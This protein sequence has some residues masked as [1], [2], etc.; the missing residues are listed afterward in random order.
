MDMDLD[1]NYIFISHPD[2]YGTNE[3]IHHMCC[4]RHFFL[5][6]AFL[7]IILHQTT[8]YKK[9]YT[10]PKNIPY[11]VLELHLHYD[12]DRQVNQLRNTV[13]YVHIN[14]KILP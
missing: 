9:K 10:R 3:I 5:S 6:L 13:L 12:R 1:T 11:V 4:S 14:E 7:I 2:S 8:K